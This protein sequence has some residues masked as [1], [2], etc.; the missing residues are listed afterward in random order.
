MAVEGGSWSPR[1]LESTGS[2]VASAA[3]FGI[4]FQHQRCGCIGRIDEL[5]LQH[6]PSWWGCDPGGRN[7]GEGDR[8]GGF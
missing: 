6:R 1:C 2:D 3:A 5:A 8:G 4:L 7:G